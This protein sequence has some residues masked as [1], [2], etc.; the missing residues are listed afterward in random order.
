MYPEKL[1]IEPTKKSP[2]IV[3]EPGLIFVM[4]RAILE[5]P[6][7]FFFFVINWMADFTRNWHGNTKIY[8]GFEF[9]NTGS[10]KWLYIL[11]RQLAEMK[12][13]ANR[14]TI[15]WYYEHG[16]EDMSDLGFIL[17]SLVDCPFTIVEVEE[18]NQKL[19]QDIVTKNS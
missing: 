3:L 15:T 11:M 6:S 19:Y 1:N 16:D 17:R 8:I 5:N 2:W 12:D 13:L 4:G 9:I 7:V 18:M 14:A 10:I